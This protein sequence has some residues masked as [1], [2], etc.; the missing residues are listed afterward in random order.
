MSKIYA[1]CGLACHSCPVLLATLEK[2]EIQRRSMRESI[3]RQCNELYGMAMSAVDITDCDGCTAKTGR[4]FKSCIN[5]EIKKCAIDKGLENCGYCNDYPC[6]NLLKHF[7]HDPGS[8]VRL[9][10]I[11]QENQLD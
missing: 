4:I 11:R 5:C 1:Y 8:K 6:S 9:E 7:E 3:A 10:A 2:D